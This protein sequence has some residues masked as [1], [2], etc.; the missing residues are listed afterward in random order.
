M[1]EHGAK[2]NSALREQISKSRMIYV[3]TSGGHFFLTVESHCTTITTTT[4]IPATTTVN[5][6]YFIRFMFTFA[7]ASPG[8]G[9][10]CSRRKRRRTVWHNTVNIKLVNGIRFSPIV[11]VVPQLSFSP[12]FF[13]SCQ[14]PVSLRTNKISYLL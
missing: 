13:Y 12:L 7:A 2:I 10:G 6:M 5:S 1:L 11:V 9:D 3:I 14:T 4:I 8:R